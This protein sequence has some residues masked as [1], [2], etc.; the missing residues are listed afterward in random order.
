MTEHRGVT[1]FVLI[2]VFP[3][4]LPIDRQKGAAL[5]GNVPAAGATVMMAFMEGLPG[6][7]YASS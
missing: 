6:A 1:P 4:R 2:P 3:D 7:A 5:A